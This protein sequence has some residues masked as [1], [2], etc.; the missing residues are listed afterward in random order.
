MQKLRSILGHSGAILTLVLALLTPFL[1]LGLFQNGVGRA[2]LRISPQ[3]T[4]GDLAHTALH[5]AY[6]IEVYRPVHRVWA[7]QRTGSF[8]QLAWTPAASLPL[9]VSDDVDLDGNGT[10]DVRVSFKAADLDVSVTPL[11]AGYRPMHS[12]GVTS[13]SE[14]IANV[15]G[16]IVV[17]LPVD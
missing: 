7:L 9:A 17:R 6:R 13:F 2:G 16:R 14:L 8:I 5:G 11:H 12:H 15:D 10:P 3:F 1:L 4:G